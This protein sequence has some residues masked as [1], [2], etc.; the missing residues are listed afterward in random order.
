MYTGSSIIEIIKDLARHF[1]SLTIEFA[2]TEM[3]DSGT[4]VFRVAI[5]ELGIESEEP[6]EEA[7]RAV[8]EHVY[9]HYDLNNEEEEETA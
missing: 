9:N 8:K 6:L 3:R 7:I 2:N 4:P 5:D 1:G